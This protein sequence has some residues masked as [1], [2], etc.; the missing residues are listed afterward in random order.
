[1]ITRRKL[2]TS[3]FVS[4]ATLASN[5]II[6]GKPIGRRHGRRQVLESME[7]YDSPSTF[8]DAHLW[9]KLIPGMSESEVLKI[10]GEPLEKEL[11]QEDQNENHRRLYRWSY[12]RL[13]INDPRIPGDYQYALFFH[14]SRL[15]FKDQ[16]FDANDV[17]V[18]HSPKPSIPWIIYPN[19]SMQFRHYPRI[20]D[21][22]WQPSIGEY[23]MAYQIEIAGIREYDDGNEYNLYVEARVDLPYFCAMMPGKQNYQWRV[24]AVN[25]YGESEWTLYTKFNFIM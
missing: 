1:M 2:V 18:F 4:A 5:K 11:P 22:R 25:E 16:P 20:I 21:C 7:S 9:A 19:N 10:L 12:G 8:P 6:Q 15:D 23:P 14:R 24:K 13:P 17:T 3:L